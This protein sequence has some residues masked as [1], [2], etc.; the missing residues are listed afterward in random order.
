MLTP[1]TKIGSKVAAR[2][3]SY[4]DDE[5]GSFII[6]TLYLFIIML[7]VGGLSVDLMRF[8]AERKHLQNTLDSAVLAASD[9]K[10]TA[11]SEEVV[12]SFLTAS[13][14]DPEIAEVFVTEDTL[15]NGDV[16]GR[17]VGAR[18]SLEMDTYLM[19]LAG[20]PTLTTN[21]G[22]SAN[23]TI[24]NVEISLVLDISGSMR[25]GLNNSNA[26][27]NRIDEL[28]DA[29]EDF[30]NIV[31]QVNCDSSGTVCVQ[32]NKTDSTTI[33]IIPYAG[34]VNPGVDLFEIMGGARW[35]VWSSCKEVTDADFDDTAL[36]DGSNHQL[37]HFMKWSIATSVMNWGW[38][39]KDD[40]SIMV[41][42]N[43]AETLKDFVRNIRLHDGTATH[44]GMKY[45]LALLDPSSRSVFQELSNRGVI[46]SA[47]ANRPA[48]YEDE[49]V[50]YIVLMTDGQ[51]TD[52]FR[53]NS[54]DFDYETFYED[55]A[56][57]V[58]A[59]NDVACVSDG[60]ASGGDGAGCGSGLDP[61]YV[62]PES[63]A[64]VLDRY[65]SFDRNLDPN[66][67]STVEQ[68][69]V[70]SNKYA[71][72][73]ITHT[74]SRNR[75]NLQ[76]ICNLA[77]EPAMGLDAGGNSVVLRDDRVTVFT[78]AFLAPS[79][80]RDDMRNCASG[81]TGDGTKSNFFFDVRTL[82]VGSAFTSIARTINQLRLT[83]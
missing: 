57:F 15:L 19:G 13:G 22:G 76:A 43:D 63:L 20:V 38:C 2:L 78:I 4:R 59:W 67:P 31:L 64:D 62:M 30:I 21:S 44:V 54:S 32:P 58:A 50:K 77:K 42:E 24:Q 51:T 6:F 8:E 11:G 37:P 53:P 60:D 41:A 40:A 46:D 75:A 66:D 1:R 48:N 5:S 16:V 25:W 47:Y 83:N 27:P 26:N 17:T 34:H 45:G 28:R 18:G 79:A 49:V 33:N 39:P 56:D 55:W 36:P 71:E 7:M 74:R 70:G 65:G 12:N 3:A 35:H 82:D 80:A 72:N 10:Q 73:S 23:E 14:F 69:Y 29:V 52:Q 9:L 81:S 68:G 61:S